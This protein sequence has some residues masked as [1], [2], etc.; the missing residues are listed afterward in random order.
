MEEIVKT[1]TK[2]ISTSEGMVEYTCRYLGIITLSDHIH[3]SDPCYDRNDWCRAEIKDVLPGV[4]RVYTIHNDSE[5]RVHSVVILHI[6]KHGPWQF[7]FKWA[8]GGEVGVDSGQCGFF[9]DSLF[10]LT[11]KT[12]GEMEDLESFYGKCCQ[13][14]LSKDQEGI[15]DEKGVVTSTGWGDGGYPYYVNTNGKKSAFMVD[16]LSENDNETLTILYSLS[17]PKAKK[18]KKLEEATS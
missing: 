18:V 1:K 6:K 13:A 2:T 4:Y 9:D 17:D 15:I 12:G 3:C 5:Q 7:A 16:Y 10:P 14:T 8:L 11:Q